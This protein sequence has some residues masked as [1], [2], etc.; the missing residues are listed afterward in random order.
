[1]GDFTEI[2][3][4]VPEFTAPAE[5]K[6][7][8]DEHGMEIIELKPLRDDAIVVVTGGAYSVKYF[9]FVELHSTRGPIRIQFAIEADSIGAAINGW[10]TAAKAA[11]QK[12]GEE[13]KANQKRIVL[14]GNEPHP[15]R[16]VN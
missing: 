3:K 2:M 12:A 11:I 5:R 7:Y 14:P 16:V 10:Q 4:A 9:S 6:S 1:V 13:M 8:V 15:F